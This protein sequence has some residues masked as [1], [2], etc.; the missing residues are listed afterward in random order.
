MPFLFS[1][2]FPA[3][4]FTFPLFSY[5]SSICLS[6]FLLLFQLSFPVS[7]HFSSCHINLSS[8]LLRLFSP[9]TFP[10]FTSPFSL[11]LSSF[12]LLL[13]FQL[14]YLF[15]FLFFSLRLPFLHFQRVTFLSSS[16]H[17]FHLFPFPLSLRP[18]N[19]SFLLLFK[20]SYLPCCS[21]PLLAS[22]FTH[23]ALLCI[24]FLSFRPHHLHHPCCLILNLFLLFLALLFP[25]IASYLSFSFP[26]VSSTCSLFHICSAPP[27]SLS[28]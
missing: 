26:F 9:L 21:S 7:S 2:T 14:S 20:L 1:A 12:S 17:L 4:T 15:P 3:F 6:S 27:N 11:F 22:V 19:F 25:F 23:S 18:L 10:A 24:F 8:F 28:S 13:L 5:F 16:F